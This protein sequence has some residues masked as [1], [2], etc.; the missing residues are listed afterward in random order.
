VRQNFLCVL[1]DLK[2]QATFPKN[3]LGLSFGFKMQMLV[4]M[5]ATNY[6]CGKWIAIN[7]ARLTPGSPFGSG[8]AS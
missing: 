2:I 4:H 8:P 7:V 6:A 1:S 5:P 3:H